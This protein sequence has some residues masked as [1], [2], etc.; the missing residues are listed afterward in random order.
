MKS[1]PPHLSG[2]ARKRP[3]PVPASVRKSRS[4]SICGAARVV[5]EADLPKAAEGALNR[6]L[7]ADGIDGLKRQKL[8]TARELRAS[9]TRPSPRVGSAVGAVMGRADHLGGSARSTFSRFLRS[10]VAFWQSE[11]R[12]LATLMAA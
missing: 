11:P 10:N 1:H 7:R 2:A 4:S 3:N 6:F 5:L 8:G 12:L 9:A